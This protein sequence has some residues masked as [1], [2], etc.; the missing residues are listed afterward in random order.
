MAMDKRQVVLVD[1]DLRRPRVHEIFGMEAQP[2]LTNV[3]VGQVDLADALRETKIQGLRILTAGALPPNSVELLNSPA[4]DK[5]YSEL[6]ESSDIIIFDSPPVLATA[7]AQVLSSRVDG[8]LY[9]MELGKVKR[10]AVQRSFEL[11]HQARAHILG[12]LFNK[13]DQNNGDRYD[14]Y[15]YYDEYISDK[16]QKQQNIK[17]KNDPDSFSERPLWYHRPSELNDVN[18]NGKDTSDED[19]NESV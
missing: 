13:V 6:K 15:N 5:L 19:K 11:L 3:L 1:S 14:A 4:M 2:G 8:V 9:V 16:T 7:D 17:Q 12:I 10:S 18:N